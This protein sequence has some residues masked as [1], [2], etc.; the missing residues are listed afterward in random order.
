MT[1]IM[2]HA[3][4]AAAL[5]LL[6]LAPA[7][8]GDEGMWLFTSPPTK[9]LKER[10]GFE[11]D[12]KWLTH[13]QKSSVRF[14]S[15]SG[16]FISPDGLVMTNHH[17]AR[18]TLVKLSTRERN[19]ARDGFLAKTRADELKCPGLELVVLQQIEDVTDRVQ[20]AVKPG[21]APAEADRARRAAISA[22]EKEASEKTK[23]QCDVVTLYQGGQYHLY[24]YRKHTDVRLVWAPEGD[25][26]HFGGDPD[27]FEFPR[28]C[29]DACFF[30]V[31][32]DGK[33]AR[34]EHYLKWS[35]DGS[36]EGD[37]VFVS[38]H[39]GRT[40]R[41][42]T[43]AHL[44]HFRDHAYP[45]TLGWLRRQEVLMKTYSERSAENARQAMGE[46]L[47]VQNGRKLYVGMMD[48]LQSPAIFAEKRAEEKKL[49]DAVLNDPSLKKAYGD[50]WSE[51]EATVKAMRE[52]SRDHGLLEGRGRGLS[53]G[54]GLNS[55]YFAIARALVRHAAETAKPNG[56]RLRE[57]R[58]TALPS[59]KGQ[60]LSPAPIHP[61][62]EA[63][64]LGDALS[65][66]AESR[67]GDDELVRKFLEGKSPYARAAE[68][69]S[70]T[71]L[72]DV[73][74]RK[75]LLEGGQK[76]IE[77]SDDPMIRLALLTDP[78]AR[79]LRRQVEER[80]EEPQ[81]QA[82]AKISRALFELRGKDQ[83]PDAT[84]TLRLAFGTVKGYEEGGKEVPAFTSLRGVF[85]RSK[86]HGGREPFHLPER[87]RARQDR[88]EPGAPFNFV[89]TADIIGGNS[90]S[91]VVNRKGE[92]VGLI[93]DGNIQSLAADFAY[94]EKQARAVAVDSRGILEAL[95][96][97]YDAE[98]LVAEVTGK[99]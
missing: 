50:A 1:V 99:K 37:L 27:N 7:A 19:I 90:G 9:L 56:E 75:A 39:P 35:A 29:L 96:T 82:Y 2:R 84:F 88:I 93:F 38:G 98:A 3:A 18:G 17:V 20:A 15:G 65:L 6:T 44:E 60:L 83:Y 21:L 40:S 33:P 97:V 58:D 47:R 45:A 34:V 8:V 68:L 11:P 64:K 59:L 54:Q 12:E 80:V 14:P 4:G 25:I 66:L 73:A 95:R 46:Y 23:L 5:A 67:G 13:L 91:P 48:G 92:V 71:K 36:R 86:L 81:R 31:Y 52:L 43:V 51:V 74:V 55:Q 76:A 10:Y 24:K 87:W 94:T 85:E 62:F 57:F 77:A 42:N 78:H 53:V 63:V 70:R 79:A 89:C 28:F 16:S 26:A 41:L 49:R 72:G 61:A 22:L 32:E 30:R 69:V